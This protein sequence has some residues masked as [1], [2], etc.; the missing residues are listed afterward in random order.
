MLAST[1]FLLSTTERSFK[2]LILFR[3]FSAETEDDN[4]SV[5][6]FLSYPLTK[7]LNSHFEQWICVFAKNF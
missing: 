7:L 1:S 3:V 6:V 5:Q 4:F 2:Y